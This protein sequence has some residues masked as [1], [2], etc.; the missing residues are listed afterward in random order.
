[1][2]E[3]ARK[4]PKMAAGREAE[5]EMRNQR[6]RRR[7]KKCAGLSPD[8]GKSAWEVGNDHDE[9]AMALRTRNNSVLFKFDKAHP[10]WTPESRRTRLN[11]ENVQMFRKRCGMT[12][13]SL[14]SES[15]RMDHP[16]ADAKNRSPIGGL[17]VY[18][19]EKVNRLIYSSN[20]DTR[21]QPI[22]LNYVTFLFIIID[23]IFK[24]ENTILYFNS[25]YTFE[26]L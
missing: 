20:L 2:K 23:N 3:V 17:Y 15:V 19:S 9:D 7:R 25:L 5:E 24:I 16:D 14:G 21:C 1:M 8:Q 22:H 4:S 11:K 13:G 18:F 12:Y 26:F 6:Q 10:A